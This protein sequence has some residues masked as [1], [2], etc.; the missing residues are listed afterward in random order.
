ML[1]LWI[2][3]LVASTISHGFGGKFL[4]TASQTS[5]VLG[6]Q[7]AF[8]IRKTLIQF[9]SKSMLMLSLTHQPNFIHFYFAFN[10]FDDVM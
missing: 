2:P 6:L 5:T 1:S 9:P 7:T 3:P 4:I 8:C 10:I